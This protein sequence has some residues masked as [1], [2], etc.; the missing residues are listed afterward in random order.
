[1]IITDE[2]IIF[3]AWKRLNSKQWSIWWCFNIAEAE[4]V[5]ENIL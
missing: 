2:N 3:D 4:I 1:M 5:D